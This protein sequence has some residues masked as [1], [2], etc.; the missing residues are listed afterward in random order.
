MKKLLKNKWLRLSA[1]IC[2]VACMFTLA[3]TPA[4]AGETGTGS[5]GV[6]AF[7]GITG[8]PDEGH[9]TFGGMTQVA[10]QVGNSAINL[11]TVGGAILM[12]IGVILV[13]MCLIFLKGDANVSSNKKHLV[14][15]IGAGMLIFGA[16][17]IAKGVASIGSS[18]GDSFD[19]TVGMVREADVEITEVA[20]DLG[21][22][23]G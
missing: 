3:L 17:G 19:G 5:S 13:G 1:F 6:N 16:L 11:F 2:C 7:D 14:V 22:M 8:V 18:V 10:K 9:D 21:Q 4:M 20:L 15:I 12:V 23:N